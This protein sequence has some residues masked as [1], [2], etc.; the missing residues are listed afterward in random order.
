[1]VVLCVSAPDVPA[2][3]AVNVP[4]FARLPTVSVKVLE[5]VVGFGLN[6]ADTLTGKPEADKLTL[7]ANP[8]DGAM[9]MVDLPFVP[10]AMLKV[11]GEADR[12]KFGPE[13][14]FR[15]IVVVLARLAHT[16]LMVSVNVPIAAVALALRVSVL[17]LA[18]PGGL[19]DAATPLGRPE[20][21]KLTMPLNPLSGLML[22]TLVAVFPWTTLKLPGEAISAK[23]PVGLTVRVSVV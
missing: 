2:M 19:K 14:M 20:A 9:V 13:V 17:L 18:V 21:D 8:F 15:E 23:V 4:M 11:E 22:M 1:M 16:P 3:V 6:D 5:E 7:P 12:P 10:R